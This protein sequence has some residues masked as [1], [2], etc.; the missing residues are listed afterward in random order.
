M[1]ATQ[2]TLKIIFFAN[3][4]WYLYNFRL[5]LA[6][7]LKAQGHEVLFISPPGSHGP[8]LEAAG[9][10][11][12]SLP[13]ERRSLN[14]WVEA[15]VLQHLISLYRRERP[16]LLHH[17]TLKSVIYGALSARLART[18]PCINSVDGM[19]YIFTSQDTK[20]HLLRPAVRSLLRLCLNTSRSRLILQNP[21]DYQEF[22][23][24][25]LAPR[26]SIRLIRSAGVSTQRFQPRSN[27]RQP[28]PFRVLLAARLLWEKGIGEYAE[29]AQRLRRE[30]LSIEFKL[31]GAPD[32]GNPAS[33]P[34]KTIDEWQQQGWLSVLGHVDDMKSL[35][36][37]TDLMVL[38]SYREGTPCSLLEAAACGL[39]I[40]TADSVGCREVVE[41]ER[42]GLLVPP[43]NALA[44]AEAIR[45]L[46]NDPEACN[47][48]GQAGRAKVLAEFD[49]QLVIDQ[50]LAVYWELLGHPL[51]RN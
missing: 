40:V 5:P 20:A 19:G 27:A 44:L 35:L 45:Q 50:T 12:I 24:Q 11:W 25:Q 15:R 31:A 4:D 42:N 14:P 26:E 6:L 23:T 48:M 43:R 29:A 32:P 30:G 38:P 46:Y 36:A 21:D 7:A 16:D 9:F 2:K 10:R 37:E 34:Q 1:S 33:I 13:M 3:T 22:L 49:E 18:P 51:P 41:H 8:R 47:R 17:F 28:G 39:P